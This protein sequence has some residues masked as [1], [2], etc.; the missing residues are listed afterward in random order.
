MA[1]ETQTIRPGTSNAIPV[2]L[3]K[4]I[5]GPAWHFKALAL[6]ILFLF[7]IPPVL[8]A[9]HPERYNINNYGGDPTGVSDN[10]GAVTAALS[11][12][13]VNSFPSVGGELYFPVGKYLFTSQCLISIPNVTVRGEGMGNTVI[14]R[15]ASLT[16]PMI[17]FPEVNGRIENLTVD[18]N[19]SLTTNTN[20]EIQFVK[21]GTEAHG[22]EV[23]NY[24]DRAIGVYD[25][26]QISNCV[27]TGMADPA[28]PSMGIWMA[29][30]TSSPAPGTPGVN[31]VV[32]TGNTIKDNG[33]VA[34]FACG[35]NVLINN[36]FIANNH[37]QVTPTGGGQ[38]GVLSGLPL[39][40]ISNV[41]ISG[42]VIDG[43]NGG[44]YTG[45]IEID[46]GDVTVTGNTVTNNKASGIQIQANITNA[47]VVGNTVRNNGTGL[48]EGGITVRADI[49]NFQIIGNH[50]YDDQPVP[51][52][53]YGISVAAGSA[54]NYV[55]AGNNTS[56]NKIADFY[57]GGTGTHKQVYGNLPISV[58][59]QFS[60]DFSARGQVSSV[61]ISSGYANRSGVV[62][63]DYA[64]SLRSIYLSQGGSTATGTF[65]N[66]VGKA[67]NAAL[68]FQN[69]S[70][71][72]G[73]IIATNGASPLRLGT[74]SIEA[75]KIDGND[76]SASF[77]SDV[78]ANHIGSNSSLPGKTVGAAA[79]AGATVVLDPNSTDAN[80]KITITTGTAPGTGTLATVLFASSYIN[81][82]FP[83]LSAGGASSAGHISRVHATATTGGI[84]IT[85]DTALSPSTS[86]SFYY[87]SL[88]Q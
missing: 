31:G 60:G 54:D 86:Y 9:A 76:Q 30:P 70:V 18:G 81:S 69:Q 4:K 42:N 40:P 8:P 24:R 2:T 77:S 45:G 15:G 43:T 48:N 38:I 39:T 44:Q 74:H 10:S 41:V 11:D 72:G 85:A 5:I 49:G 47:L 82:P 46:S 50:V 33:T 88:G 16:G 56:G 14:L 20:K 71:G 29:P 62:A 1:P 26:A 28:I 57:D 65:L 7:C 73:G 83:L 21:S 22:V 87:V 3:L 68:I 58:A 37:R 23:K 6:S 67:S 84:T 51:T 12:M 59:N 53:S 64:T 55:I 19:G 13:L 52:Q 63:E 66:T 80:G 34:I 36:N 79:G 61:N 35:R 32:I 78:S 75:L 25:T 27:I 17:N